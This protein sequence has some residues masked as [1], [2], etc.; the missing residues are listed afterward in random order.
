MFSK[1]SVK[2]PFTVLVCV[3]IVLVMGFVSFTRMVPD[4][5]PSINLPYAIVMTTYV[6]AS[7]EEVEQTVTR[8]VEQSM[9][10]INN[11]KTVSSTSQENVSLVILEFDDNANMDSATI[12]MR[13]SLDTLSNGWD[14]TIGNPLIM[15]LNPDMLPVMIAALSVDG[16]D[17][18]EVSDYANETLIPMLEGIDGIGS[19]YASGLINENINVVIRE[20]KVDK[21]NEKL[22]NS[23]SGKL[24]DAKV[25]LD[26][27]KT[28]IADNKKKLEDAKKQFNDGMIQGSQ[29]IDEAKFEILK[30]EIK[31]ANGKEEL[32]KKE[33]E[34]LDGLKQIEE[35]EKTLNENMQALL[36]GQKQLDEGALQIE[37]G[38][39]QIDDGIK[40]IDTGLEAMKTGREQLEQSAEAAK[41]GLLPDEMVKMIISQTA[42]QMELDTTGITDLDALLAAFDAKKAE[43]E[44]M[45]SELLTQKA[46]LL[47][48]SEE[49]ENKKTELSEGKE[50]LESGMTELAAAKKQALEGKAALEAAK[51]ELESG[52]DQLK[53]AKNQINEKETELENTRN[54]KG[55]EISDGLDAINEGETKLNETLDNWDDTVNNALDSADVTETLTVDMIS[56]ILKAQNF[57]MPAGYINESDGS[58]YLVKIGDKI[59]NAEIL[60]NL[61][62]FDLKVDGMDPVRLSDVADVFITDN[63][64]EVYA[65]VDGKDG[66][67][68]TFQKQNNFATAKVAESIQEKFAS[69]TEENSNVK[70]IELMNQGD[71][72][73]LIVNSVIKNLLQGAAF[74]IIVLLLFLRDI[75]PTFIIACSIPISVIFAVAL[76]YFTGITLNLISLS[77]L[78]IGVGMLV[79]NSVVVIENIYRLKNKG[80]SAVQAS[81]SGAKQV[82]GAITSS[83]LT[84]VCVFAPIV[85]VEGITKTLFVDMALTIGF[86]LGASLIVALTVVP[87]MTSRIMKNSK[88]VSSKLF[89]KVQAAYAK[90]IKVVLRFKAV[91]LILVVAA[92]GASAYGAYSKGVSFMPDM[93]S[94][95]VSVDLEMPDGTK[96]DETVKTS[97]EIM[98]DISSME[99]VET[100]GAMLSSGQAAMFGL[101]VDASTT[102]VSMYVILK[103]DKKRT[104]QSIAAEINEKYSDREYKVTASGSQMDLSALGGSGVT[105]RIV[106]ND[107]EKLQETAVKAAAKLEQIEGIGE[108]DDGIE[109]PSP[110][111]KITVN[112]ETAM[113]NGLTV[114]QV[115]GDIA[116]SLSD[117]SK[118]TSITTNG[119]DLDIIV[120]KGEESSVTK[121]NIK[122]FKFKIN[123]LTG[124]QNSDADASFA[125]EDK[126]DE[127]EEEDE[128]KEPEKEEVALSEIAEIEETTTLSAISR[129][130]HKRYIT[131][132]GTIAD[133]YNVGLVSRDAE[134][135]FKDFELPEGFSL[136]FDGENETIM[137]SMKQLGL[138]LALAVVLIYLIMVAQFQS[139][140]SPFIV[141]FTMPLA[142]TGGFLALIITGKELSVIG[143]LGFVMLAGI[144]VNNGIVLVDYINQLRLDGIEKREA[145]AEAGATR[146]RPILMTAITTILGLIMMAVGREMGSD[147]VQPIAVVTI[148]GLV[149][150]TFTTLFIIPI[151]Y[152]IFNKKEMKKIDN[153]ELEFI[154]D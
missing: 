3:I 22:K 102:R 101:D 112:K 47:N 105:L 64:D 12:D 131:V 68:L 14:D 98:E 75:R 53:D 142:F 10:T 147:M 9:S 134:S 92:L 73:H 35:N 140:K 19:V 67:I 71:Y 54:E 11:I 70:F 137:E 26:D 86:S 33:T 50:K 77:G 93:D 76:M 28:E 94:T 62:L 154:D 95:Q 56:N 7:P 16:M 44:K 29:G 109:N 32:A 52:S 59:D 74:A 82:A 120:E 79:D 149:Y 150:A 152:D 117:S 107:I 138:M 38:I 90:S 40:A 37:S 45:R 80:Y 132:S 23:V 151:I 97:D 85:F 96:L 24:D 31:L 124:S 1:E 129:Q 20:E 13:E 81:V 153:S 128:E 65:S 143:L 100:I 66:V 84:T 104:S 15:K 41:A 135:Q 110:E 113:L 145:I 43:T 8:P 148:G 139:L 83:T 123:D 57:A 89:E 46:D 87:A 114:A 121:E 60:K 122:D 30:N 144:V 133:G 130:N 27:A 125:L 36:D 116:K 39:K 72:I 34:L 141:M 5:L 106:G 63:S 21:I 126:K 49:L 118:A 115:F 6:G 69:I 42:V 61:V 78:A 111:L 136:E 2:K 4:L 25:K 91:A 103:E 99:D 48:K 58:Q 17:N 119:K 127:D 108:V 55:K 146:L 18:K 51:K 88:P